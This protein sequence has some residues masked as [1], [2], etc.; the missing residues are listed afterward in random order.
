MSQERLVRRGLL[1]KPTGSGPEIDQGL[2]MVYIADLAWSFVGAEA[3]KIPEV[4]QNREVFRF[5]LGLL[6]CGPPRRKSGCEKE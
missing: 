1:S 6:P 2:G 5:L 3:A 4:T